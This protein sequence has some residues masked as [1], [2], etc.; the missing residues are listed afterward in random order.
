MILN[1][2]NGLRVIVTERAPGVLEVI[3]DTSGL[4]ASTTRIVVFIDGKQ[5][6]DA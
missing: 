1:G 3:L 2:P 6:S 4:P 5:L